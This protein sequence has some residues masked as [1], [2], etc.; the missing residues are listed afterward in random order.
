LLPLLLQQLLSSMTINAAADLLIML[1]LLLLCLS[2]ATLHDS[3][4]V[5]DKN[6]VIQHSPLC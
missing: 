2:T 5:P 4:T 3:I 1:L 6:S